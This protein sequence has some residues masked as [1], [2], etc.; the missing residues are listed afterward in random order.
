M[1]NVLN[2]HVGSVSLSLWPKLWLVSFTRVALWG[3]LCAG[4]GAVQGGPPA[5]QGP[6]EP[7]TSPAASPREEGEDGQKKG[8]PQEEGKR[9]SNMQPGGQ[10]TLKNSNW[11]SNYL[12]VWLW[13]QLSVSLLCAPGVDQ[14]GEAQASSLFVQHFHVGAL[15][16]GQ[17]SHH[18]GQCPHVHDIKET[19]MWDIQG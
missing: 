2:P 7:S 11:L 16:G 12:E 17:W 14:P 13:A 4:Q 1:Y 5:L 3:S 8:H 18:T 9:A 10:E 6:A 19:V 15:C